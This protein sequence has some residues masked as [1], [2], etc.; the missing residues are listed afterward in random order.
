MISNELNVPEM[1][2]TVVYRLINHGIF[3]LCLYRQTHG[4]C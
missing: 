1:S 2:S 3:V 4:S